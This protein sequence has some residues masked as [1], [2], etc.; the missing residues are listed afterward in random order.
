[1]DR[2]SDPPPGASHAVPPWRYGERAASAMGILAL[3]N[4]L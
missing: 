3:T 2:D 4:L 1:M